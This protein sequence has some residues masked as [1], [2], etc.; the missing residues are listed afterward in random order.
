MKMKYVAKVRFEITSVVEC[1]GE[2]MLIDVAMEEL[3]REATKLGYGLEDATGHRV[4]L[5]KMYEICGFPKK[6]QSDGKK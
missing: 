2:D 1:E 5:M 4:E 3:K 6:E